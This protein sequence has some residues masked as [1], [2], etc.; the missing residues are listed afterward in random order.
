MWVQE[1]GRP[2]FLWEIGGEGVVQDAGLKA[3]R[4]QDSPLGPPPTL[5]CLSSRASPLSPQQV[6][7]G[8]GS[9]CAQCDQPLPPV[10]EA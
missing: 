4:S 10:H 5:S 6:P 8:D 7:Q 9:S 3:I 2:R 1:M